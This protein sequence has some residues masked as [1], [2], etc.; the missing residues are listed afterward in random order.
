M[1]L[2]LLALWVAPRAGA[3]IE[4]VLDQEQLSDLSVAPRAGAWIEIS[5]ALSSTLS[6]G[7]VA[8]RAERGLKLL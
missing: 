4:I 7:V 6:G 5:R 3:W 8:P 1:L 2:F